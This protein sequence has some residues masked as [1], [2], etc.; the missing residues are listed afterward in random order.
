MIELL[1]KLVIAALTAYSAHENAHTAE[2][3][4]AQSQSQPAIERTY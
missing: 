3:E 2:L 1:L 4:A